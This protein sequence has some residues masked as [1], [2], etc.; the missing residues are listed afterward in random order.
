MTRLVDDLHNVRGSMS[1]T[2]PFKVTVLGRGGNAKLT[3]KR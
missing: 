1:C 2:L 3:A